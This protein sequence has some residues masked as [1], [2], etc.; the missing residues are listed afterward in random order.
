MTRT[1]EGIGPAVGV[2]LAIAAS[3]AEAQVA[4]GSANYNNPYGMSQAQE[5]APVD[6]SLRDANG[7]LTVVNGVFTSST[8]SQQTGVQQ[9]S[10]LGA[11]ALGATL[12]NGQTLSGAG[13]GAPTTLGQATAIGNSLNVVTVGEGNTVIVNAEQ[14]N[15]GNVTA[16]VTQNGH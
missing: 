10:V 1:I 15:N 3:T 9:S 8:M 11:A 2:F 14:T 6:A 4:N 5:N 13:F 12:G 7:N 16:S